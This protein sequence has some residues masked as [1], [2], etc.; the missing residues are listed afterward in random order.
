MLREKEASSL[1]SFPV[2]CLGF[3]GTTNK[4]E[5]VCFK[6]PAKWWICAYFLF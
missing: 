6:R 5:K 1:E 4:T 3:I 2:V